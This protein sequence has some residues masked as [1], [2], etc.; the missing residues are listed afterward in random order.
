VVRIVFGAFLQRGRSLRC[1]HFFTSYLLRGLLLFLGGV[2]EKLKF[3][4]RVSFFFVWT[5][6]LGKI[7]TLDTLRNRRVIMVEWCCMCKRSRESTDH[8]LLHCEVA[9]DLWSGIFTL[10]KVQWVMPKR[11]IEL[12]HCW[13]GQVG[14]SRSILV[15]WR[16]PSL[17]L[18]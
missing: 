8:L 5:A 9:R 2:F 6:A 10:S 3:H 13:R 11:V 12:L 15:V 17:C 1:D 18:M 16:I 7:L 4:L 14:S